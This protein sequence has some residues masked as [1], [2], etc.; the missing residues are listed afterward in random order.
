MTSGL[1][2]Q[3]QTRTPN[4]I[5][6]QSAYNKKWREKHPDQ[7]NAIQQKSYKKRYS[8]PVKRAKVLS[9]HRKQQ[10]DVAIECFKLKTNTACKDCGKFDIAHLMD[11]DHIIKHPKNRAPQACRS[12]LELR[13]ELIKCEIV[14]VRCHRIRTHI[15][16][17][18]DKKT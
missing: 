16:R 1:T 10:Q 3:I 5:N 17:V 6:K 18:S 4:L 14:C 7:W 11:F 8:D 9:Y 2:R 13:R 12:L 15:R